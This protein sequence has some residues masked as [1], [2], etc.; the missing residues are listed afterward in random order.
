MEIYIDAEH[1]DRVTDNAPVYGPARQPGPP[2]YRDFMN[3][4]AKIGSAAV[5]KSALVHLVNA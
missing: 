5:S 2:G 4:L 3:T 1:R